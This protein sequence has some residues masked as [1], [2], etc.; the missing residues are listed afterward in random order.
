MVCEAVLQQVRISL[1]F[2]LNKWTNDHTQKVTIMLS[3]QT[4]TVLSEIDREIEHCDP[5]KRNYQYKAFTSRSKGIRYRNGV[6]YQRIR[7]HW[8]DV[9]LVEYRGG[10]Y[11]SWHRCPFDEW[12]TETL[13]GWE[14]YKAKDYIMDT[15]RGGGY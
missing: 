5:I 1:F 10:G 7:K 12:A 6:P 15:L 11:H 13:P 4:K 9:E 3:A 2:I 8:K 14:E